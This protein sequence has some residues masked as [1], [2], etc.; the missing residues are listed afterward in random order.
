MSQEAKPEGGKDAF[1]RDRM[2]KIAHLVNEELPAG[3]GFFV[4]AFPFNDAPGRM[5]FVSNA[6]RDHIYELMKE[7]IAKGGLQ[8]GHR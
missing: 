5:N 3:W 1:T 8:E 6:E 4:M 2:Q 7:F